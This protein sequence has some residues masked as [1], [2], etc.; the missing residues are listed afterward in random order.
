MDGK[1]D[2]AQVAGVTIH[3]TFDRKYIRGLYKYIIGHF[4]V[5][6]HHAHSNS[7]TP[8]MVAPAR[9]FKEAGLRSPRTQLTKVKIEI[10]VPGRCTEA[11]LNI[12][13][14]RKLYV[15]KLVFFF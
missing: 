6:I 8:W 7:I 12:V 1:I 4:Y 11:I 15:Y 13:H 5:D 9:T 3:V 10:S 14:W 2:K